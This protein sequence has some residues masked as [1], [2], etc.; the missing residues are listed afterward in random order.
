MFLTEEAGDS[1]GPAVHIRKIPFS[2][3]WRTEGTQYYGSLKMYV[4]AKEK[5]IGE[6]SSPPCSLPTSDIYILG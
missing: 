5:S 6:S 1:L 2:S 4:S 3:M